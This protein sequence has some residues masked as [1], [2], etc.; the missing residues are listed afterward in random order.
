MMLEKDPIP[1]SDEVFEI[2]HAMS[3]LI[4]DSSLTGFSINKLPRRKRRVPLSLA[5]S[6]KGRGDSVAL[7]SRCGESSGYVM[8]ASVSGF[9]LANRR[10]RKTAE[11]GERRAEG[12]EINLSKNFLFGSSPFTFHLLP[13]TAFIQRVCGVGPT[14]M[15][16]LRDTVYG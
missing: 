6:R 16:I 11:S 8:R 15:L 2:K 10:E 3:L 12:R 14:P 7:L 4:A 5:L 1:C 9:P 13:F